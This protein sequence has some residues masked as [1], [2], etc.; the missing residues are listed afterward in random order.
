MR[1]FKTSDIENVIIL[2]A[3][4]YCD[5]RQAT[6]EENDI[7]NNFFM[8]YMDRAIT[9][10]QNKSKAHWSVTR[11]R[12][13]V[14]LNSVSVDITRSEKEK[15][16]FIVATMFGP[17]HSQKDL[18]EFQ[19]NSTEAILEKYADPDDGSWVTVFNKLL[20]NATTDRKFIT[21][22]FISIRFNNGFFESTDGS[23]K[24]ALE[25]NT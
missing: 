11:P 22:L 23:S 24:E 25:A 2:V 15:A 3:N 16:Q 12:T 5:K 20:C 14:A 19:N 13:D 6:K 4:L 7:I 17:C 9:D 21:G 10:C 8:K 18:I 1:E